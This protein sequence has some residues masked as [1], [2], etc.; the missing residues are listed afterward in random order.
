MLLPFKAI[1]VIL[2]LPA[3]TLSALQCMQLQAMAPVLVLLLL[4]LPQK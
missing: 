3:T 2:G 1:K 4:L